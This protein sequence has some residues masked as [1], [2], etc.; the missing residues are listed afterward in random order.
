MS[1]PCCARPGR[2]AFGESD[3]ETKDCEQMLT[4]SHAEQKDI[5]LQDPNRRYHPG[6][7]ARLLHGCRQLEPT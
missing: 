3:A 2:D 1:T 7:V 5:Q 6:E 4:A